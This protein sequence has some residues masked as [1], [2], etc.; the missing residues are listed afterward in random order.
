MV[1]SPDIKLES[2]IR[3]FKRPIYLLVAFAFISMAYIKSFPYKDIKQVAVLITMLM[4]FSKSIQQK[5]YF[6]G[7]RDAA[8]FAVFFATFLIQDTTW[9][10][11]L[12]SIFFS[13][14]L[15]TWTRHGEDIISNDRELLFIAIGIVI[16]I[17]VGVSISG[18]KFAQQLAQHWN[19]RHRKWGVFNHP[20]QLG[21][22]SLT[23]IITM[24]MYLIIN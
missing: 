13:I 10:Q 9:S 7:W 6:I 5:D 3:I 12:T 2:S 4:A 18:S 8:I 22:M 11:K 15:I 20:N 14:T 24:L 21:G 1:K 16:V 19:T 17:A 23:V